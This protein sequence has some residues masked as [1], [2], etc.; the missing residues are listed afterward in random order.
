VTTAFLCFASTFVAVFALGLQS[1]NVNQGHYVAAAL[2]SLMIGTSSIALYKFIPSANWISV[3]TF[4]YLAGGV[5]GITSSMY[6]HR[7]FKVWWPQFIARLKARL[8]RS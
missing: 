6:F 7:R 8:H 2:T 3:E 5:T 1:L 4:G